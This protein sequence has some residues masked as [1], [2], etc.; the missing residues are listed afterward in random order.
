MNPLE[1]PQLQQMMVSRYN[2][3]CCAFHS[4]LDDPIIIRIRLNNSKT[5]ARDNDV[6]MLNEHL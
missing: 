1:I 6:R 2:R 4:T 3:L 5:M